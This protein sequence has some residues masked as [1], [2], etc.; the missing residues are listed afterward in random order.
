MVGASIKKVDPEDV[1]GLVGYMVQLAIRQPITMG[2]LLRAALPLT[3]NQKQAELRDYLT[4]EEVRAKLA[5][6]GMPWQSIY[7]L[8]HHP[9]HLIEG[10]VLEEALENMPVE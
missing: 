2:M 9:Q 1:E 8:E 5:A 3:L 7:Q 6:L 10:K 4:E